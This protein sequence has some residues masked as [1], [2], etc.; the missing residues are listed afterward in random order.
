MR[1]PLL[2]GRDLSNADRLDAPQVVVINQFM[3]RTHWPGQDAIGK[4]ITLDDSTWVT[5]V[6]IA[7]NTVRE[8]WAAPAEEEMFLPFAQSRSFLASPASHFAY[9]T[10]VARA[11]C[12]GKDDGTECDAAALAAPIANAVRGID[13]NVAISAVQTM[14]AVV[15]GATAESRFY[16]VLLGTFASI[17]LT[18]AAVGIYGVMSYSVSRRTHEIGIRVALGAEPSSVLMLVVAQGLRVA[19]VGVGIGVVASFALTRL[20]SKLLYGVAP[21]D[22]MTFVVVTAV[23]CAV[24]VVASYVPARRATRIDPLSALRSD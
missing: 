3:A 19:A 9:L 15:G 17:A 22:P 5:V 7:K 23:L 13:R 10:L 16:V 20:M 2:R 11:S 6:G 21:A 24:A 4:R 12:G 14:S 18:L 1:I 8:Q